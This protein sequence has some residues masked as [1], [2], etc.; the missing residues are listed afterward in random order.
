MKKNKKHMT[1]EQ[2]RATVNSIN[3]GIGGVDTGIVREALAWVLASNV[4]SIY[5]KGG[6]FAALYGVARFIS[7]SISYYRQIMRI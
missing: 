4:A 5:R 3:A 7:S 6:S 1:Y 2:F